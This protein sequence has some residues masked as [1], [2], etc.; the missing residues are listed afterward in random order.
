MMNNAFSM[1]KCIEGIMESGLTKKEKKTM[2]KG[3][4]LPVTVEASLYCLGM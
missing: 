1:M 4:T 2:D 3:M